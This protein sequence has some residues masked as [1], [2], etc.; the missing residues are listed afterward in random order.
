M[1]VDL[2]QENNNLLPVALEQRDHSKFVNI[3]EEEFERLKKDFYDEKKSVEESYK[4]ASIYKLC[5]QF[6]RLQ[7]PLIS[8]TFESHNFRYLPTLRHLEKLSAKEIKNHS[9]KKARY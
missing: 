5:T 4:E 7:K 6:S 1:F 9:L 2:T 3:S 8:S